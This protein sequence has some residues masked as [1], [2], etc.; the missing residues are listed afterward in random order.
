MIYVVPF[1]KYPPNPPGIG[2]P[3]T[4]GERTALYFGM[5][6]ISVLAAI[7]ALRVRGPGWS[8]ASAGM[9]ATLGAIG[10]FLGRGRRGWARRCR[11]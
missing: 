6:A 3:A 9:A 5:V 4:I 1:V 7:A 2:D 11:A 8:S 10:T